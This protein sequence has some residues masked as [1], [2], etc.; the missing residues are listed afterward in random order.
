VREGLCEH[1]DEAVAEDGA[2]HGSGEGETSL[3]AC[4]PLVL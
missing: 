1:E 3:E 2:E 4:D